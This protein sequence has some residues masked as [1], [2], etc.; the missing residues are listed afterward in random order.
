[1]APDAIIII[2]INP[3]IP[4]LTA[5]MAQS[6]LERSSSVRT[7][8]CA[9][10]LNRLFTSSFKELPDRLRYPKV[11]LINLLTVR[12]CESRLTPLLVREQCDMFR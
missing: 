2:V 8:G 12:E 5:S 1:M 9:R 10:K 6:V 11:W 4:Q 3:T 7:L